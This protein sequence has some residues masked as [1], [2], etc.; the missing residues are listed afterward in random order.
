MSVLCISEAWEFFA[1]KFPDTISITSAGNNSD[2]ARAHPKCD[3]IGHAH[4]GEKCDEGWWQIL[5]P[6]SPNSLQVPYRLTTSSRRQS[7]GKFFRR[8]ESQDSIICG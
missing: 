3:P 8:Y 4:I 1:K 5:H 7:M 2:Y 6:V